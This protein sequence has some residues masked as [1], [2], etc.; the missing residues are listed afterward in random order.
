MRRPHRLLNLP[1]IKTYLF[2]FSYRVRV[3]V[4]GTLGLHTQM[5]SRHTSW[6]VHRLHVTRSYIM[7][8]DN[9]ETSPQLQ[10]PVAA[11]ARQ[12]QLENADIQVKVWQSFAR[13]Q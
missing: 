10:A 13:P 12:R 9:S 7:P 5:S 2:A 3:W 4:T 6:L 1:E 8:W 11:P